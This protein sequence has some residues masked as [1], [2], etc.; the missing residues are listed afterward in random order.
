MRKI[1]TAITSLIQSIPGLIKK[2]PRLPHAIWIGLKELVSFSVFIGLIFLYLFRSFLMLFGRIKLIRKVFGPLFGPLNNIYL[3]I[4][5][6]FQIHDHGSINSLDII[7][8]ASSHLWVKKSRS[9]IAIGGMAI[10]FGAVVFLLSIGYGAEKLVVSRVARLDELKQADVTVGK[11]ASLS[12]TDQTLSDFKDIEHVEMVLPM[13]SV[14]SKVSYNN[15]VSDVVAYAVSS[16]F[17]NQ[18]AIKPTKGK[19]FDSPLPSLSALLE[20]S[21]ASSSGKV[22]G[23]EV[24]Y[25]EDA[26]ANKQIC[27]VQFSLDPLVWKPV[28]SSASKKVQLLGYTKRETEDQIGEELWGESYTEDPVG[29]AGIDSKGNHYGRWIESTFLVWEQDD[30]KMSEADCVDG[31]HKVK[32][33]TGQ[34]LVVD[35]F[36]TESDVMS[37][38]FKIIDVGVAVEGQEVT[39]AEVKSDEFVPVFEQPSGNQ[40]PVA[41]TKIDEFTPVSVVWGDYYIDKKGWGKAG[42]NENDKPMGYWAES[43]F[44]LWQKLDCDDCGDKYLKKQTEDDKQVKSSGY[45]RLKDLT[46]ADETVLPSTSNGQVL[47]VSTTAD[48]QTASAAAVA[49]QVNNDTAATASSSATADD[50]EPEIIE[51]EVGWVEIASVSATTQ[52]EKIPP[53][54]LP[55][56][57]Q[58]QA[59]VNKAM[60]KLLGLNEADALGQT[61]NASF[62]FNENLFS[63]E[64]KQRESEPAE[65]TIIG[66]IPG[67]KTPAF[68][69][70]FNDLKGV[71]VTSYP[72]V[73]IVVDKQNA[74]ADVR[75]KIEGLGFKTS[76]VVDTVDRINSLFGNIRLVL[77]FLG[78][79]AL[80]VAALGMFNTLTVS[81]LERTRE[82]GLMKAM[83]MSTHE[84]KRLFLTESVIMGIIG[85]VLGLLFGVVL[86][87]LTSILISTIS[88]TKGL[89]F[90]D[91]T[92]VPLS[93]VITILL[94][95]FII[96][97]FTGFFPARRATKISALDALRY[98]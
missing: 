29:E 62:V 60:I 67:D 92:Y 24:V 51:A 9:I 97:V 1:K 77:S 59:V 91:V 78:M 68:Y 39:Q 12:I 17:L 5:R 53:L 16:E 70:P 79:I 57:A 22:A 69:L 33:E 90:L 96:G 95:S 63:N 11:A 65:Y 94:L 73:K 66:V 61:F 71:G 32:R 20:S 28:Y 98:E 34:Q 43:E 89:G 26:K 55:T 58:R 36:I 4:V 2:I 3:K 13:I 37:Q 75:D 35:G 72:Q 14:V 76:S 52:E 27:Q 6:K 88:V 86:G 38:C 54:K 80:G 15:S 18:S 23:A 56:D 19:I 93:L 45:I 84:V 42:K 7:A 82:V 41:Y 81:L 10:G 21:S 44:N 40:K 48:D 74:L 64:G 50:D 85:G 25:V 31:K 30:C 87:K 46:L 47:G 49:T 8:L 83:G